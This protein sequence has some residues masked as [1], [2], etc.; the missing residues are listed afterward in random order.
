M[1]RVFESE[2]LPILDYQEYV[3]VFEVDE[4]GNVIANSHYIKERNP[5][6]LIQFMNTKNLLGFMFFSRPIKL[7][8]DI[9][10]S[11]TATDFSKFI[12][13]GNRTVVDDEEVI[14]TPSNYVHIVNDEED[15][16]YEEAIQEYDNNNVKSLKRLS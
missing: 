8:D 10:L 9:V 1:N 14:I 11:G 3:D 12:I 15:I 6:Y 4:M 13:V 5:H 7:L 2:D 16:T